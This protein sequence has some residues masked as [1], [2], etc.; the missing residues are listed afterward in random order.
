MRCLTIR[1][2]WAEL[3]ALG[4]KRFETRSW[5]TAYRGELA[6]HA[7]LQVDKAVCAT[8]PFK[9][10]LA[11]HGYTADNL[12]LGAVIATGFLKNCYE[13]TAELA[14]EGWPGGD[15]Y[16]FGDY[17][18]GR[19]AWELE[20]MNLLAEPVPAKGKLGL[21]QYPAGIVLK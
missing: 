19:F 12:P 9:S 20:K 3:V 7:G 15:E 10:V 4:E 18:A 21:W 16:R 17:T 5:R 8:E 2:P 11:P 14:E 6:V 13:I 1:Q